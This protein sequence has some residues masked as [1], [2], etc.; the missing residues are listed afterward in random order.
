MN[1]SNEPISARWIDVRDVLGVV[2]ADVAA[3]EPLG[4]LAVE[5]DGAHLPRPAERVA[6]VQVD[7]RPVERAVAL[8]DAVLEAAA[9]E[10]GAQRALG[11]VPLLVAAEPVLRPG[12]QLEA[13]LELEQ[14]VDELRIVEA[15][16]DLVLDLL[17]G[18][19]DV[20]VVLGDV[21]HPGQPVQG[22]GSLVAVKRRRLGVAQRQLAVAAQPAPRT[23]PCARGSSSA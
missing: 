19:E 4:L 9:V 10:R 14:V 1:R 3:A 17:A 16:E 8:V 12:R 15:A 7:L 6:H 23:A 20:R 2:G 11:E 18:A 22:P 5:L 21:A 13:R